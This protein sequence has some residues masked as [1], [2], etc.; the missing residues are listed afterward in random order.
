MRFH[1]LTV[2]RELTMIQ[3]KNE[4]NELLRNSGQTD[5]YKIVQ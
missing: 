2:D 3:L 5:K 4:I 1:D